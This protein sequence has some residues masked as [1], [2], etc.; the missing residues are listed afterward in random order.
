MKADILNNNKNEGEE[1][2]HRNIA[3]MSLLLV[4]VIIGTVIVFEVTEQNNNVK[5][6]PPVKDFD[7]FRNQGGEMFIKGNYQQAEELYLEAYL[8]NPNDLETLQSLGVITF[9]QKKWNESIEYFE[10]FLRQQ[11]TFDVMF[12]LARA[13]YNEAK[14]NKGLSSKIKS[15]LLNRAKDIAKDL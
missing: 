15:E 8:M 5:F 6:I 4:L 7:Y 1:L 2:I 9:S 3:I 12:F 13:Y 10:K 11:Q 14:Y